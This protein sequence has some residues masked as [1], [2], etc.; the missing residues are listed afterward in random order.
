MLFLI[1]MGSKRN[2]SLTNEWFSTIQS[3]TSQMISCTISKYQISLL[4]I[5]SYNGFILAAIS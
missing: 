5:Y 1:K 3:S 2:V 4:G